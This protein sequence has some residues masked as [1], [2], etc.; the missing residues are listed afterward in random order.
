MAFEGKTAA[1]V[2]RQA[3]PVVGAFIN[4]KGPT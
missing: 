4:R 2:S 3:R 1:N